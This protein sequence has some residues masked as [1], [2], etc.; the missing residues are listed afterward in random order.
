MRSR[1]ICST[2]LL[3]LLGL[4]LILTA[5]EAKPSPQVRALIES[6]RYQEAIQHIQSASKGRILS[7]AV[8]A[9]LVRCLTRLQETGVDE[10]LAD[11]ESRSLD[12][13][14]S[15]AKALAVEKEF[16]KSET[17]LRRA[18]S[19]TPDS[20]LVQ[21]ELG[22]L[23]YNQSHFEESVIALGRAV[24]LNP[25]SKRYSMALAE[26]LLGWKRSSTATEFLLAVKARFTGSPE[27]HYNLGLGYYGTVQ[28]SKAAVEFEEAVRLAPGLAPAHFFLGNT[29]ANLGD[30]QSSSEE[31]RKAIALNPTNAEY[32]WALGK[33]LR[34]ADRSKKAESMKW[35][36]RALE[37]QPDHAPTRF[38]MSLAFESD[39][40]FAQAQA[41]LEDLVARYPT[42]VSSRVALARV[43]Y[44][45]KQ[46]EKSKRESD[47]VERLLA[48]NPKKH[49]EVLTPALK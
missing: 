39:G 34:R 15:F 7:P 45:S 11:F 30:L 46:I 35:L 17:V 27:F 3:A 42:E 12:D 44:R 18:A 13:Q 33:V 47:I 23:L 28:F 37:L 24:Q 49:S 41:L 10:I 43:Y 40:N 2:T 38:E 29:R 20:A 8:A 31:Y 36:Q 32:C 21:G 4:R 14:I 1:L 9:A 25:A 22:A 16:S 48:E 5:A 26:A 19:L 6:G